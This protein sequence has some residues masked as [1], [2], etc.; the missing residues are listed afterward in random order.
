MGDLVIVL[1]AGA[2]LIPDDKEGGQGGFRIRLNRARANF[3]QTLLR[4]RQF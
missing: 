4:I 3:G 2:S 1:H